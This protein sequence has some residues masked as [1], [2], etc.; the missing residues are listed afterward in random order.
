MLRG[1]FVLRKYHCRFVQV[2]VPPTVLIMEIASMERVTVPD[3]GRE[4]HATKAWK[5]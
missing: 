2:N 4:K 3:S 1:C 5:H